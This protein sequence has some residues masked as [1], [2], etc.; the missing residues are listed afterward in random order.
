MVVSDLRD[1]SPGFESRFV[2]YQA[3][4]V[5]HSVSSAR[6]G[7]SHSYLVEIIY[8]QHLQGVTAQ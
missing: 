3:R 5:G 8:I 1:K 6:D 4:N 2:T 7:H